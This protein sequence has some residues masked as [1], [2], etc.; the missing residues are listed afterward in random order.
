MTT[1]RRFHMA[2]LPRVMQ[3][4]RA[5][6]GSEGYSSATFLAH[7][8]RDRK[9]FLV[10]EDG[11]GQVVGYVLARLGL[12]WLGPKKGGITSIAVVPAQ[13]RQG[14]G[15]T[16]MQAALAYLREHHTEQA[17]LE[18]HVTNLAA[19]SLYESVGFK[20]AK[21]LPHYYGPNRDGLRMVLDL[22]RTGETAGS[23]AASPAQKRDG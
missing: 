16:L 7:A 23:A 15:R 14:L 19:Q 11:P 17:D 10:A 8:F 1:I 20:R 9:G 3:I 4:E 6:F 18:V 5:S 21:V 22:T 12:P 2:D 13:R